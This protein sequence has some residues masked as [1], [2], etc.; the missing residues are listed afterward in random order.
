MSRFNRSVELKSMCYVYKPPGGLIA[1]LFAF[2]S[3]YTNNTNEKQVT[4]NNPLIEKSEIFKSS[5]SV[6][7]NVS[8]LFQFYSKILSYLDFHFEK[9][10]IQ[11]LYK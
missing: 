3:S 5:R 6:Y 7:T 8:H 1:T 2:L 10:L 11:D 4:P 9:I